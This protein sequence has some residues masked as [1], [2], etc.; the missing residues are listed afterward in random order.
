MHE[1]IDPHAY[2]EFM[3]QLHLCGIGPNSSF[4]L[5]PEIIFIDS[6]ELEKVKKC[7][8]V[9]VKFMDLKDVY[10]FNTF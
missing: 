5:N 4:F 8:D 1:G 10:N 3:F 2:R 9:T 6:V 7:F